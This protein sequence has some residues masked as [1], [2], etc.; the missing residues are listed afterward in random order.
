MIDS[1]DPAIWATKSTDTPTLVH[2]VLGDTVVPN[3]TADLGSSYRPTGYP[4][5]GTEG[6]ITAFGF[7]QSSASAQDI[8]GLRTYVNF[9][10][11]SHGSSLDPSSSLRPLSN[12]NSDHHLHCNRWFNIK[13]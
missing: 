11:G 7:E 3:S 13:R 9:T 12:T 6:L 10:A 5:G 8:G 4:I 1:G 2:Q